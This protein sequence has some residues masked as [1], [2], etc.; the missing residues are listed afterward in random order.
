MKFLIPAL[1]ALLAMFLAGCA[2]SSIG[3][4][5]GADGPT[6][7]F[8][9]A[10]LVRWVPILLIVLVILVAGLVLLIQRK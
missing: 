6:S 5:G 9:S 10:P 2:S 3:I 8:V 1:T 7:I 4:I